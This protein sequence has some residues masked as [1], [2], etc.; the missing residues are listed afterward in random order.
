MSKEVVVYDNSH[1]YVSDKVNTIRTFQKVK[2]QNFSPQIT[3]YK[4]FFLKS[5]VHISSILDTVGELIVCR[6]LFK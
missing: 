3:V 2:E 5:L 6:R 1:C 4:M